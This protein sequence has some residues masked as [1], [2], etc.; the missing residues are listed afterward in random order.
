MRCSMVVRVC[1]TCLGISV[2]FNVAFCFDIERFTEIFE[3]CNFFQSAVRSASVS[4][5][6]SCQSQSNNLS[7]LKL[8]FVI[9]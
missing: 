7:Q 5:K 3:F 9:Q 4:I 1:M 6:S 2:S 8:A